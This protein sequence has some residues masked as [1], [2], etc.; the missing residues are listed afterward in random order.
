M[1]PVPPQTTWGAGVYAEMAER[2]AGVAGRAVDE[3]GVGTGDRVLDVA[4][5]TGTAALLAATRGASVVGVDFEPR[6]LAAARDAAVDAGVEVDWLLGDVAALPVPDEAF[7]VVLSVFGV[8][9]GPDQALAARELRRVCAPHACLVLAAWTPGSF[10]PAMGGKLAPHLPPPPAGGSSPA[11]WGD[12]HALSALLE[13]T[14][15]AV[16]T[17]RREDVTLVFTDRDDA[18]AFLVRTAG[19]VVAEQS[20]LEHEGR[21]DDLLAELEA[22]VTERN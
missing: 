5:G 2:L 9:Y 20:R 10:M 12:E 22:F 21:W 14:G 17:F 1:A 6:L 19:H 15:T 4:C 3:A 7:N 11:R 16:E 13:P 8:M 18:V